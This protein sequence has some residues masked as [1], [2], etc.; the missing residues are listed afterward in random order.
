MKYTAIIAAMLLLAGASRLIMPGER[1]MH[2]DEAV[3]AF[4]FARLLEKGIYIYDRKEYHGPTL[5]YLSLVPALITPGKELASLEEGTLRGVT[6]IAG[7]ALATLMLLL[8][9][10]TGRRY[11]LAAVFMLAISPALVYY[12]RYYIHETLLILFNAGAIISLFR[13][14]RS[15]STWW[16]VIA[17]IF[18]GLMIATKET[19]VIPVAA[20]CLAFA[21]IN[22][23]HLR[24]PAALRP[25]PVKI[26]ALQLAAFMLTTL[27]VAALFFSSFLANPEGITDSIRAFG[28]Y[29]ARGT[30]AT[31]HIHPW[32]YY[33]QLMVVNRCDTW[34]IRAD[35]WIL[36]AGLAAVVMVLTGRTAGDRSHPVLMFAA[37]S[38]ILT[39]AIFFA[40]PYKTPWNILPFYTPLAILAAWFFLLL[41]GRSVRA[42]QRVICV[43]AA[44]L[45]VAH[46]S[47]QTFNDNFRTSH[48][49]C[50]PWVYAHPGEDVRKIAAEV[51]KI[52][53]TAPEGKSIHVE[54]IVPEHGY[55]PL[56]WYLR[57]YPNTGWYEEAD[58]SVPSAPLI[59]CA[60]ESLT[61]LSRKL[62]EIPPPGRRHLYIPL[63]ESDPE[64]RPGT[65][66]TLYLR[67]DYWD[68][69][70]DSGLP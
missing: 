52:S 1:P 26:G 36:A 66:V 41:W 3:H 37:I 55:W 60:P 45:M 27:I 56:P 18:A 51:E 61:K 57:E 29:F 35:A 58:L 34:F 63:M 14:A 22:V 17:G 65:N 9:R 8:A 20:Q 24:T 38:T 28:S 32:Y 48:D 44:V 64:L 23:R 49:P 42:G 47:W 69:Y 21:I 7:V 43:A 15:G 40:I 12:S 10:F 16:M 54:V 68:R 5:Y 19:W 59:I 39:G 31:E 62:F 6:A 33:L 50:N 11:A 25:A 4:K 46:I 53:A 13:Y 2:T 67:K 30:G 70:M